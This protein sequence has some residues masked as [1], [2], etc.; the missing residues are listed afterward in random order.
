[1]VVVPALVRRGIYAHAR[2]ERPRECCGLLV[3]S[4]GR[5][6]FAVAC[7][8]TAAEPTRYRVD[9]RQHLD[10]RRILR[11]TFPALHIIGVYHSHPYGD[12][13]PSPTD[14]AEAYYPAWIYL[15]V[16]LGSRAA[17]KGYRIHDGHVRLMQVSSAP[18]KR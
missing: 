13:V 2:R 17:M 4:A 3:G 9:E 14:V 16:G 15:I 11:T 10:L 8:N 1:M 12:P 5:I 7:A 6:A 18:S